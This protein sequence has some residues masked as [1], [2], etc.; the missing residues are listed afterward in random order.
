METDFPYLDEF[1]RYT[2]PSAEKGGDYGIVGVGGNLSPGMLLSAYSQGVFPWYSEGEPLLWWNP[3]PRFVLFPEDLHISRSLGR[4]LRK[5]PYSYTFDTSFRDVIEAC[6]RTPRP[7]QDGTWIT[8]EM[9]DGYLEIHAL[10]Y[11]HSL[12]VWRDSKLVGG[13]YGVSLGSMFFGESMFSLEKNAS[14]A[15]LV[16]LQRALEP[17]GFTLIDCQVYTD[18]LA[19]MGAVDIQRTEFLDILAFGLKLPTLKGSWSEFI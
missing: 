15:G 4:H 7:G 8:P 10:G 17:K 13:L 6:S 16:M 14:K 19:A 9:I 5:D 3:D 11:A 18:H 2:F 1:S 12:E